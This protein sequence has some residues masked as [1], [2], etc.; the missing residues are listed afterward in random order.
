MLLLCSLLAVLAVSEERFHGGE[1]RCADEDAKAG[2]SSEAEGGPV[3]VPAAGDEGALGG[4]PSPSPA[5]GGRLGL[6]L[7]HRELCG[8]LML[9]FM[10]W[11][12][13]MVVCFYWTQWLGELSVGQ[14]A[15]VWWFPADGLGAGL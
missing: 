12:G 5:R 8:T 15:A 11:V 6:L 3:R 9:V 7:R 14:G 1:P 2:R 13:N 10:G 4:P